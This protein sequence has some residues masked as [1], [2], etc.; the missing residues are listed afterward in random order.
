MAQAGRA[1]CIRA[2]PTGARSLYYGKVEERGIRCC[3]HGWLFDVE[4]HC[5]EQPCEPEGGRRRDRIRQP[6]YPVEELYGLVFAY[7]GPPEKK[8]VLPRYECLDVLDAANS[9]KPT[10]TASAAAARRSFRA[11][12]C[13]TTRTWWIR[14]TSDPARRRSAARSSSSRWR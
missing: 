14:F 8:P 1:C 6:W 5:L 4:G 11:T 3:Y 10:T 13:S 7:M 12:G 2:A 9:S